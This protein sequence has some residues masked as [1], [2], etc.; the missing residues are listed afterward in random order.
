MAM[1]NLQ[2]NINTNQSSPQLDLK[3]K[4]R[5]SGREKRELW[6]QRVFIWLSIIIVVFPVVYIIGISFSKGNAITMDTVFPKELTLDNYK[7]ILSGE[8]LDFKG[9]FL[10]TCI[11]CAGVGLLQ[12][13]MTATSAYAVSKMKFKGRKYGLFSLL[14]LQMFPATMTV[15]AIFAIVNGHDLQGQLWVLILVLAGGSAFNVWL[16]KNFMDGIPKELDEAAKVDGASEW[17]IFTKII[18]PLARP[19]IAVM[20]FFSVQGTYN[21]F[22]MSN[23]ILNDPDS[24]TIMPLLRSYINGQ[25]DTNWT[26]FAAG[27]VLASI[28]LVILFAFL[29]KYIE[30]GLVAGAVKG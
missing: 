4:K 18:L 22:I 28:P 17:Q 8:K 19:M 30:S 9:A 29:Q 13:V 10:R 5:L 14:I 27:S 25:Y 12:I 2:T 20:F 23:M 11:V 3:Y 15:S 16:L 24:Q 26:V 1:N 7:T 21:E 6:L